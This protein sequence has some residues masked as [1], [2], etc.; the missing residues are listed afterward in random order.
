MAWERRRDVH[1][2]LV[3]HPASTMAEI[4][5]AFGGMS[6]ECVRGV[7]RAMLRYGEAVVYRGAECSV[8]SVA[9]EAVRHT[10][11]A[12]STLRACGSRNVLA[13]VE[14]NRTRARLPDG[15]FAPVEARV[16]DGRYVNRPGSK[17]AIRNQG[18]QGA[19]GAWRGGMA[20][21]MYG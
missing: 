18:G 8:Y 3:G 5:A 7:V 6:G 20:S 2:W 17:P 4:R 11:H 13:R 16:S 9:A 1:G 12:R 21:C 15:T 10:D 19:G 14:E